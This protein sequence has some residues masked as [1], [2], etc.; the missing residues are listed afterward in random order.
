[1]RGLIRYLNRRRLGQQVVYFEYPYD[2]KRRWGTRGNPHLLAIVEAARQ[3]YADNLAAAAGL[4]PQIRKLSEPGAG[5]MKFENRFMPV[6]D[7]LSVMWAAR[8][9]KKTFLEIGSGFSTMYAR[10][11][12][13]DSTDAARIISLDPFPRADIDQLCDEVIRM[14]AESVD[15]AVFDR[16]ESGDT[17]FVDGSHRV[18]TNSDVTTIVLDVLPR[19]KPGVLV[20]FHDIFIPFDYPDAWKERAYNEQYIIAAMLLANPDFLD[21]Q[22]CSHWMWFERMHVEPL[23]DIWGVVGE[24]ARDRGPTAFWGVK[25]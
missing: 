7:G 10:A 19:L 8:R 14:P 21:L 23:L 12:I 9:T 5:Q 13:G 22:W 3:T 25:R 6:L 16:L 17:L 2:L 4:L 24:A 20:G 15:L 1:M 11:G 18:L